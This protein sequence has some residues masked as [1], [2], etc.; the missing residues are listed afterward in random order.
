MRYR[1][2]LSVIITLLFCVRCSTDDEV[3][4]PKNLTPKQVKL[5]DD[6]RYAIVNKHAQDVKFLLDL[7]ADPNVQYESIISTPLML[8]AYNGRA[9]LIGLL[10][11]AGAEVNASDKRGWTAL[12]YAAQRDH[13]K[14]VENLLLNGANVHIQDNV[15]RTALAVAKEMD[16]VEVVELLRRVQTA[17]QDTSASILQ[18]SQLD[19]LDVAGKIESIRLGGDPNQHDSKGGTILMWASRYGLVDLV[20][21]LL[22]AKADVK[23]ANNNGITAL[24][25]AAV[26]GSTEIAELLIEHGADVDV[27]DNRG[28]TPLM[29]AV[30]EGYAGTAR[31]LLCA[32]A[33][34]E[35]KHADGSTAFLWA[36]ALGHAEV[37]QLLLDFGA[38][39]KVKA[40]NGETAEILASR[41]EHRGVIDAI[42]EYKSKGWLERMR[43]RLKRCN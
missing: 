18:S 23:L 42:Q 29:A 34:I 38:D 14:T 6:L 7:R 43:R 10:V 24:H 31:A 27:Q 41:A 32:G 35:Q 11:F 3:T 16:N 15:G 13:I 30:G 20:K 19:V 26:T 33:N 40:P 9:D 5:N 39:A 28:E 2:L 25:L 4:K 22:K 36:A 12:M 8:A 1:I 37:V 21:V 17:S